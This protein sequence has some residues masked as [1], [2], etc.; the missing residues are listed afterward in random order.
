MTKT[1]S[2]NDL[3]GYKQTR[4]LA[5]LVAITAYDAP[6]ARIVDEAG[7]DIILVG[8]S[9]AMV[10]AG[11]SSTLEITLADMAYHTAAVAR[12]KP[13]GLIV[14]DMPWLSY[15]T[16][17]RD[18]V[19]NAAQLIRAGAQCVKVEGASDSRLQVIEALLDAEIPVIGHI[20]LTPQ[21][22]VALGGF[23]VQGKTSEAVAELVEQASRVEEAGCSALVVEA[24][25]AIV[26]RQITDA[27][28]IP[29]IGVGA[30][31]G[32]DGQVIVFH[33]M[34]GL[35]NRFKPRFVRRYS[36]A[37]SD[38]VDAVKRYATDVR[39]GEFPNKDESY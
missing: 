2:I 19:R 28:T 38:H 24:V 33:D 1:F 21:S 34:I 23:K 36:D 17:P 5:P 6:S 39:S 20:G 30:G 25:P 31:D 35:E 8:D 10:I 9:A 7:V 18:A 26:G 12:M 3:V 14:A 15:H 11:Y 32:T 27:T 16:G 13:A 29:T 22:A 37:Y 4:G